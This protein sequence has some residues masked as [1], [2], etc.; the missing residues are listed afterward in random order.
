MLKQSL[1]KLYFK[2]F[3]EYRLLSEIDAGG[4]STVH[5]AVS[6]VSGEIV[7]IKLLFPGYA[8]QRA[9]LEKLL[10]EKHV[11]GDIAASLVHPGIIR[12]YSHG[13]LHDRY[14][15]VMEY[16]QGTNLKQAIRKHHVFLKNKELG[17]IFQIANALRYIHRRGIIHRDVC[18]KNVLLAEDGRVKLIDFGLAVTKSGVY[19][20]LGE[21]SGTP[22]YM[23]PEQIRGQE[24]D[25][26]TD[27]YSFG[28]LM[29]E[30]LSGKKPFFGGTS[31][32]KMQDNLNFI[33]TELSATVKE[34][35]PDLVN[36]VSKAMQKVPADRYGSVDELISDL[37]FISKKSGRE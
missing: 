4:M 31:Y 17:I 9:V 14:Y 35:H 8:D 2:G 25:E 15:F 30:I 5:K 33:P 11:E 3:R 37:E 27:I 36:V 7:A 32:S 10:E 22:S 28:I 19:R 23:S 24:T 20:Q 16:I 29:Y 1:Y 18:S 26:R 13:R 21:R 6:R 12:T 34:I